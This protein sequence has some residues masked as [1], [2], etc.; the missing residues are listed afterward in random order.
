MITR[1]RETMYS[2]SQNIKILEFVLVLEQEEKKNLKTVGLHW[3]VYIKSKFLKAIF[4]QPENF[5]ALQ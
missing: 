5:E 4:L 2:S 1:K 3:F